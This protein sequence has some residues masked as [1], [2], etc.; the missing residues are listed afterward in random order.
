MRC[1]RWLLFL[2]ACSLL[3]AS[4]HA[5]CIKRQDH[6]SNKNSGVSVS[7]LTISGTQISSDELNR[8]GGKLIGG[9]FDEDS[10]QLQERLR[11]EF[12]NRGYFRVVVKSLNIKA[13][14]PLVVPK[15]VVLDAEVEEG[16]L[17]RLAGIKF[18]GNRVLSAVQLGTAF[19]LKKAD[20][21]DREKIAAGLD[22]LRI[23]YVKRGFID[24]ICVPDTEFLSDA[25]ILL[26]M[27]VEEGPQYRLG[28]LHILAKKEVADKLRA[29]WQLPEGAV[30]D[31]TY[32][33][34]FVREN[35]SLLPPE[36]T[37]DTV[38]VWEDCPAATVEV[39][40]PLDV[41]EIASQPMGKN[42]ACEGAQ[43]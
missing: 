4:L 35:R 23:L 36:F 41:N 17:Y 37:A 29:R 15:P 14:D 43:E 22:R 34:T 6:R 21:F 10:D 2:S 25:T 16:P 42:E 1:N 9:C 8:I 7:D 30:F 13:G 40:V 32:I 28:K 33:E 19:P 5:D 11:A 26:T 24:F 38:Q 12:Q 31:R 39:R 3:T 18:S 20:L 27:S